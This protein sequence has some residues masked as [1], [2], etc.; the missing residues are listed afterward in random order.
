MARELVQTRAD[1]DTVEAL[2]TY[3]EQAEIS[4]SEAIRRALRSHL[5]EE[6]YPVAAAD[7]AGVVNN[8]LEGLEETLETRLDELEK[9]EEERRKTRRTLYR[10]QSMWAAVAVGYIAATFALPALGQ[11]A[12]VGWGAVGLAIAAVLLLVTRQM[13][14]DA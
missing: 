4:R 10:A 3:A 8:R 11:L 7:G 14:G 9:R 13:W 12:T 1:E 5:A 6:G 2:E